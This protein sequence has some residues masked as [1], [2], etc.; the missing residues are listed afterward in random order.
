MQFDNILTD[1]IEPNSS[2]PRGIDIE[3]D[4]PKMTYLKDSISRFG[5]MVP[6]VV[7]RRAK[8]QYLL[9]DG[10]RRYWASK[11]LGLK[12][13][14][15]YIIDR[16][17]SLDDKEI[18]YRMFQIH[19]NREQWLPVQQCR[20]LENV[21]QEIMKKPKIKSIRDHRAQIKGVTEE[22]VR[23]TG[24]E[25]RLAMNRVYFLLWPRAIKQRLYDNPQ[26]EGYWYICEIEE[27]IIIPAR[28][29][30]AEYFE[31]VPVDE[32]RTALFEK[33][34]HHSVEK[35]TEVRRVAPF[36]RSNLTK[37]SDRKAVVKILSE[38]KE[39]KEMT[40][41]DAQDEFLKRFPD[42]H[43]QGPVSPRKFHSMLTA[44]E[45]AIDEFDF[46]AITRAKRR[47]K[48][49]ESELISAVRSLLESLQAILKNLENTRQ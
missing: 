26:E 28:T 36:F 29:N 37:E 4:D 13:I 18:L 2:N 23:D 1:E 47:A 17:G 9:I 8:G 41:S 45:A 40:Y 49:S 20:A 10:E 5:V 44:M 16:D 19:H 48:V 32:V 7:S 38:L 22:L 24:L 21:F 35:S 12:K 31:K 27:K 39:Q 15:A 30:Y 33:L 25:E 46:G 11:Q 34:E 3:N 6:I 14:P 42:F 43:K